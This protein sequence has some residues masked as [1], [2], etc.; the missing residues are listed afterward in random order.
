MALD[1]GEGGTETRATISRYLMDLADY[2]TLPCLQSATKV[3]KLCF[4]Q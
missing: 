4:H 2:V 1:P 3:G